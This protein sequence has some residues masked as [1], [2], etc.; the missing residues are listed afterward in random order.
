MLPKLNKF[1]IIPAIGVIAFATFSVFS[2]PTNAAPKAKAKVAQQK[3]VP[4]RVYVWADLSNGSQGMMGGLG[5][6]ANMGLFGMGKSGGNNHY[7]DAFHGSPGLHADIAVQNLDAP[8]A[9]NGKDAIPSGLKLGASIPLIPNEKSGGI[10]EKQYEPKDDVIPKYDEKPQDFKMTFYWGCGAE[11]KKGNSKTFMIK[12]GKMSGAAIGLNGRTDPSQHQKYAVAAALWPNKNDNRDIDKTAKIF[13][14]HA[15]SGTNIPTSLSF[16]WPQ[17]GEFMGD[18]GLKSTG[19]QDDV[20]TLTWNN[21][22]GAQAYFFQGFGFREIANGSEMIMWS[23]ADVPEPGYGLMNYLSPEKLTQYL[24]EKALLPSSQTSCQIPKGIFA[25][26]AFV[27][28]SG[29][30]YGAD[31]NL[32]YPARPADPKVTWVQEWAVRIRN[33][34]SGNIMVGMPSM[35]DAMTQGTKPNQKQLTPEE[36]AKAE[37]EKEKAKAQSTGSALGGL[38]GGGLGSA[39]GGALGKS[40]SKCPKN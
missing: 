19:S 29:M 30:G 15:F 27:N 37:C 2:S 22:T 34:T 6:L 20:V 38:F 25:G 13:G 3:I 7:S 16:A 1:L 4:P 8:Y 39:I 33:K 28:V 12:N 32:I 24:N 23:S 35:Q 26:S 9:V 17:M 21:V 11:L 14:N 31:Q 36:I 18:L 40:S 10:T 5:A